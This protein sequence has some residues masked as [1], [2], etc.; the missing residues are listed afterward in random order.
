MPPGPILSDGL[1]SPTLA[2]DTPAASI[3]LRTHGTGSLQP[4]ASFWPAPLGW[5]LG[6][7]STPQLSKASHAAW[8]A[9]C[10]P[11]RRAKNQVR[12]VVRG[13]FGTPAVPSKAQSPHGCLLRLVHVTLF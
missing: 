4:P 6:D 11:V 5:P 12:R 7:E 10:P 9:A 8:I 1:H 13:R 2:I 3:Q